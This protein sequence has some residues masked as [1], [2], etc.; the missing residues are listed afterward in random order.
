MRNALLAGAA[1]LL[2]SLGMSGAMAD[3]PA[4]ADTVRPNALNGR[5]IEGRAAYESSRV[6]GQLGNDFGWTFIMAPLRRRAILPA[7]R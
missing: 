3:E 7:T 4:P 5:M 2:L 1:G 6:F